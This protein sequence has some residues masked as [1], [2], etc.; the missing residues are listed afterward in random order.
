MSELEK[1]VVVLGGG[2]AGLSAA[3]RLAEAGKKV[4]LLE[5]AP[6]VGGIS[7]SARWRDFIV[8]YGPHTYHVKGDWIDDLVRGHYPGELPR[9]KRMTRMLIR[10]RTFDYPLKFWQLLKGLNP[11][12][13]ARMLADFAFAASQNALFP[14]P[15]ENF[16]SWGVKRFGRTLYDLCFGQYTRRVWGRPPSTLSTRLASQKLHKLNLKDVIVKLLGGRGQ[17]QATYWEDFLY[18][19]E[20]MGIV[21]DNMASSLREKG[22]EVRLES[23]PLAL[24]CRDGRVEAVTVSRNGSDNRVPCSAVVSTIPLPELSRLAR[25]WAPTAAAGDGLISR[26]LLLVNLI[27][28]IDSFSDAHWVYLIDPH[29]RF[30]R[31]C[32]Q[33][34]LLLERKPEGRTMLTFEMC[35]DHGD[36]DWNRPDRELVDLAL[37]DCAR[38]SGL[39]RELLLE[40]SVIRTADAYPVYALGF[41][42]KLGVVFGALSAA[43]NLYSTGRQGLFLNTDMHDTIELGIMAAGRLLKRIPARDW[44]AAAAPYFDYKTGGTNR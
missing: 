4:I 25:P 40:S 29:F 28:A 5:K 36:E 10:G 16:E 41:E 14:R 42:E 7:A 26:S 32:E 19:E 22:G 12:F 2:P 23:R 18:P 38:I 37:A 31:F 43:E 33:K 44:Y 30:N 11:F 6:K 13:S 20:G 15:D 3:V 9:K 8:E 24:E 34:N 1:P 17:E 39:S 27:F 35:C 21:W